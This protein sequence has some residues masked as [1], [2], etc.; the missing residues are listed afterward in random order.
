MVA[1]AGYPLLA[2]GRVV[3]VMGMFCRHPLSDSVLDVMASVAN[4]IAVGIDRKRAEEALREREAHLQTIINT[5]PACIKIVAPDGTV[6][7]M[8]PA[9]LRM[10]GASLAAEVVGKNIFGVIAPE[11]RDQYRAFHEAVCRG[12][13]GTLEYDFVGLSGRRHTAETV[14]APLLA[15]D[16]TLTHLAF[17]NDIT[18]RRRAEEKLRLR[19]R[20]IHA[21]T[22]GILIT[23]PA[24]PDN[25]I[26]FASPSFERLT[27]YKAEEVIGRNCRFL[28]GPDTD[29]EAVEQL[30]GAIRAA[31]P[32]TVEILNYRKDGKAFWNAVSVSPVQDSDGRVTHF[33]G[34][35]TDVTER[36]KL[37]GQFR[38]SQKMD[39][40][41]RLAGGVAHDFNNL[42]TI[43][44]GY[45]DLLLGNLPASDPTRGMVREIRQ[46]GERAAGLTRQLLVFSRQQ[47]VEPKVLNLNALVTDTEKMLRRLIGEDLDLRSALDPELGN[48]KADAGQ[49]EQVIMNLVVNARDAMPTGGK[50]TI[51]T[52]NVELDDDYARTH[53]EVK[54]GPYVMLAVADTGCGM[55]EATKARIFEPFFTTKGVGQGTGLGLATVYGI[56]TQGGGH[57][58]V[59]SEVG[60]GTTFKAYFPRVRERVPSGKSFHGVAKPPHGTETVLVAEDEDGVRALTRYVLQS[61]GYTVLEARDG[62]EAV[63]VAERHEGPLHRTRPA[64]HVIDG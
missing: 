55:D 54:P 1:F 19:D 30:R 16:G 18:E 56:V 28:Q 31:Q 35:Q 47:V 17:T 40:I 13:G 11:Y 53:T 29:K 61:C 41:G 7:Q 57:L 39:A 21:V 24:R 15:T 2:E 45:S 10:V 38:Q 37:E 32:I 3:G 22:Q 8:N 43:I 27:G 34:V 64:D 46:A 20:A 63:R 51:E 36:K 23:D 48:V 44:S 5:C 50:V 59:Y 9:G 52:A 33:V 12:L 62:R 4:T 58:A 25:P 26:I 49:V 42:L 14:G 60:V 6:L